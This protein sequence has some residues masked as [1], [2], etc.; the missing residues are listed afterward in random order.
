MG[1]VIYSVNLNISTKMSYGVL[2]C[3]IVVRELHTSDFVI[4]RGVI[5]ARPCILYNTVMMDTCPYTF[6]QI[7]R[8]HNTKSAF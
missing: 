4:K 2:E 1:V 6:V 8:I 7:H 5:C 3:D